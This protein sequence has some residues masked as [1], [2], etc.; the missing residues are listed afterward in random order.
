MEIGLVGK[1]C[2]SD[3]FSR[4]GHALLELSSAFARVRVADASEWSYPR[5]SPRS[6]LGRPI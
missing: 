5:R 3:M 4:C 1:P 6:T 2:N